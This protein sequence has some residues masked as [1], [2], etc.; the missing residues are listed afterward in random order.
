MPALS[1]KLRSS[2]TA[3]TYFQVTMSNFC[4]SGRPGPVLGD[5][6]LGG[7]FTELREGLLPD[8]GPDLQGK[9]EPPTSTMHGRGLLD[10][11][12][13]VCLN[14]QARDG[15]R[16]NRITARAKIHATP[17]DTSAVRLSGSGTEFNR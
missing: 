2:S 13:R 6:P 3:W 8:R 17:P 15:R 10:L 12:I 1:V 4:S 9:D 11:T 16:R 14:G 7:E 5:T